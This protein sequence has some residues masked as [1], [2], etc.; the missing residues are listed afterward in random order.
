[1]AATWPDGGHGSFSLVGV[2]TDQELVRFP[3]L[4]GRW[5]AGP[6]EVAL[7]Q[8]AVGP[9]PVGRTVELVVEGRRAAWTVVGVVE[10][11][12]SPAAAYVEREAFVARTGLAPRT[13]RIATGATSFAQ[14]RATVDRLE[15]RLDERGTHV[16]HVVPIELLYNAMGEHVVVLVQSLTGLSLLM[17]AVGVLALAATTSANVAERTREL[18]VLRAVGARPR[19]VWRL[20][21]VEGWLV[22]VASLPLSLLVAGPTSALVGRVVGTLAFE[23]PLPLDLSWTAWLTWSVAVLLVSSAASLAP[24]VAATR[25][26]VREALART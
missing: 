5:P 16:V 13:L 23:L 11:V 1:M 25:G 18:A 26:T 10:E 20:V 9:S 24:A 6:D 14:T 17:A 4:A 12:A 3:L 8:V 7:N 19:Q 21:L 22:T 15:R 2:P